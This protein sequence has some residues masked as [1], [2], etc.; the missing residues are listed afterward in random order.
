M[1]SWRVN[2]D[3]AVQRLI[4][5]IKE[6]SE[7]RAVTLT[8]VVNFHPS[9]GASG[10]NHAWTHVVA[11]SPGHPYLRLPLQ[12]AASLH[13]SKRLL[14]PT[15]TTSCAGRRKLSRFSVGDHLHAHTGILAAV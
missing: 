5:L 11:L 12:F 3:A 8:R 9:L 14:E 6:G 10:S 1:A 7:P 2:P 15:W 4:D 13:G